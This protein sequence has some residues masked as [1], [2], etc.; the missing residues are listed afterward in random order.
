MPSAPERWSQWMLL[1]GASCAAC[2]VVPN[3]NG[4]G[5]RGDDVGDGTAGIDTADT[6]DTGD[7]TTEGTDTTDTTTESTDTATVDDLDS[8]GVSD[9]VDNCPAV[10][11]PNQRDFDGDGAGNACDLSSFTMAEGELLTTFHAANGDYNCHRDLVLKVSGGAVSLRFDD[12]AALVAVEI[13]S[14]IF[15]DLAGFNCAFIPLLTPNL[16]FGSIVTSNGGEPFPVDF[17]HDPVAHDA[18]VAVGATAAEYPVVTTT[19]LQ[20]KL[21]MA[22]PVDHE[23]AFSGALP[24]MTVET[25]DGAQTLLLTFDAPD[26]ALGST[27]LAIQDPLPLEVDVALEGLSGAVLLAP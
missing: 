2:V 1:V 23:L 5:D 16:T 8:D 4:S 14:L 12:D 19:T 13:D 17:P 15:D 7:T 24:I 27:V 26:A 25:H 6:A 20:L 11:N 3:P 9:D 22:P 10:P 18:G 21:A